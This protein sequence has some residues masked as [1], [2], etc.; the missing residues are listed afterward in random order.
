MNSQSEPQWFKSTFSG[1]SGNECVECAHVPAGTL[2]RDSK[3]PGAA[4]LVVDAAAWTGFVRALQDD[5][6]G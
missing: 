2:V 1:G 4:Q 3:Q 6:L 5:Q